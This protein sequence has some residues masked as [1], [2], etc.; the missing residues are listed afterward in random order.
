MPRIGS[1]QVPTR[2]LLLVGV[3][4]VGITF[5]LLAA[6][7]IRLS[8]AVEGNLIDGLFWTKLGLVMVVCWLSLYFNDL[9]DFQVVRRRTNLLVCVMQAIGA[10][11]I[12]LAL[13]YFL[14]PR[15]SLGRGIALFA[16]PLILM[17]L[18]SWRLSANATNLLA[19]G[20]ERVLFMGTGEAGVNLVRHILGHPEYNIKVV[21][22]L[23]E[24]GQDIGKSLVNP[25]IVGAT[26]E[27]EEIVTREK[28]D[29]VVLS[30]KERRGSTP[31]P[32]LLNLKFAGVGVED[33]HS[34]FE[35]LSGRITLEHLSPSWLILSDGFKKSPLL[36]AAKRTMDVLVSAAILLLISPV[37]PIVALAILVESGRPV[38][39][40]QTRIGYKGREFELIKF[41]SMVQDA[42][43]DGPKWAS[44]GDSRVTRFGQFLR[45]TRLDEVPQLFNV[46]RGEMSLVGP[47]PERPMFC[48]LLEEKIPY[49]NFRHSARP[50]LTGWAQVRFR[51]GASLDDA[52]GKLELDLF[53]LKN[54]SVLLD[55]A[56]LFETVKVVL[57]RRGAQ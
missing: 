56:I 15:A 52:K 53:Y 41:R 31:V 14:A 48:T 55:M 22:F 57:L 35:R 13:I 26:A 42:E 38:F 45:K 2:T 20:N 5:A 34:C 8:W 47:R 46:F 10:S 4:I 43:K 44:V 49:F 30:L 16:S 1:H 51:Y 40:R 28:I 36:L 54:L 29:R 11:C 3:D 12:A 27:I 7:A 33:V 37:L 23:D 18:L 24:R 39:F 32:Q 17:I 21:G 6:T 25:N 9:Y 19:R 50:G